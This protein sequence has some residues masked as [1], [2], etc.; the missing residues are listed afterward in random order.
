MYE[1]LLPRPFL[2]A[3]E[4]LTEQGAQFKGVIMRKF[5]WISLMLLSLGIAGYAVFAYGFMP[6][7]S[8]F[9]PQAPVYQAHAWGIGLHVGAAILAMALGPFQFLAKVRQLMP[10]AHRW[11]GRIYLM[12]VLVGGVSGLYMAQFAHGGMVSVLGFSGLSLLWLYTGLRAYL[13][14]RQRDIVA[15]RRWMMR[16]F[17]LT[18]AA[19][20]LRLYL[21]VIFIAHLP[22]AETYSAIA[23]LCWVPNALVMEWVLRRRNATA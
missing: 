22:F 9:P 17:A 1:N 19:I 5:G 20:T 21:P 11:M 3:G 18:A 10:R 13:S 4:V 16:N 23:W 7:G 8:M 15:H 2:K 12:G 6:L 14:I